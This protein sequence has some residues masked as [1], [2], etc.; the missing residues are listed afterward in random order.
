[1]VSRWLV[2]GLGGLDTAAGSRCRGRWVG[3]PA[4]GGPPPVLQRFLC[5]RARGVGG[6]RHCAMC[7][8]WLA[9]TSEPTLR[10]ANK[11]VA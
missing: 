2:S 1:V 8:A 3:G 11:Q 6:I 4:P 10:Q 7:G 5:S 9:P